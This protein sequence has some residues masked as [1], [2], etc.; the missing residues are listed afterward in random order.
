MTCALMSSITSKGSTTQNDGIRLLTL[1]AL[2]NLEIYSALLECVRGIGGSPV[3]LL[4]TTICNG[5]PLSDDMHLR[6]QIRIKRTS[7]IVKAVLVPNGHVRRN[8]SSR[9]GIIEKY[10]P[11]IFRGGGNT[12]IVQRP[13]IY[14]DNAGKTLHRLMCFRAT[15]SAKMQRYALTAA[16]G[17]SIVTFRAA[18]CNQKIRFSPYWL[19]QVARPGR[20]LTEAAIA[21]G[22][23][24][25]CAD[26]GIPHCAAQAPT[27]MIC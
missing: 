11:Y 1:S 7:G 14:T 2:Y 16:T 10:A 3:Q 23:Q 19:N 5:R 13:T 17:D 21:N 8:D 26:N 18:T 4:R 24:N 12:R 22:K 6:E 27:L 9:R 15:Q 20:T 25:R